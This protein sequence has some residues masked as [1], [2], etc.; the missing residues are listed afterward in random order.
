MISWDGTGMSLFP[1][2]LESGAF[3]WPEHAGR[4]DPIVRGQLSA[5]L[6]GV[7]WRRVHAIDTPAPIEAS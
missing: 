6:E 1:K 4:R 2:S 5:L 7:D 3:R